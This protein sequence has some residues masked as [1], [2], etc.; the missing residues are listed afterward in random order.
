MDSTDPRLGCSTITFRHRPLDE[1]LRL[2]VELGF[3]EIDLGALPGVCDHVPMVLDTDAIRSVANQVQAS[4]LTVRSINAD[5][6]D[7]NVPIDADAQQ[8]RDRHVGALIELARAIGSGAVVLPCGRLSLNP[9]VDETADLDLVAEQLHR[10]AD[11]VRAA[12]IELWVE[13]LHSM[14]FCH[15]ARRA[16]EL[17]RRLDPQRVGIVYD[18]S[19]VVSARD[20]VRDYLDALGDRVVHVHLRDAV[21]GNIHLSIGNGDVDFADL[22]QGLAQK[23]F[24][25]H[26]ALELETH[27]VAES[28]RPEATARARDTITSLLSETHVQ[29]F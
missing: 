4:G 23:G 18:V 11:A 5:V 22:L 26:Y 24:T 15:D 21:P 8:S 17:V 14:R 9:I 13:A 2:I 20:N 29:A 10:A 16:T 27:D 19:H 7:L 12:G 6:G 1:A 25:G 28:D 3:S